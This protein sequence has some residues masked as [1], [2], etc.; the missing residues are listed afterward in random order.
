M[1]LHYSHMSGGKYLLGTY[2]TERQ[3]LIVEG[4]GDFN[5]G[6]S[7]PGGVHAPSACPDGEGGIIVIFNMNPAKPTPGWDQIMSLPR[8]LTLDGPDALRMEP[9]ETSPP[10]AGKAQSLGRQRCPPTRRSCS[11]ASR[12]T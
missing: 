2:D 12:V 3:K 8:R 9:A 11:K 5:F 7:N 4:G 6:A 1:L 10:C